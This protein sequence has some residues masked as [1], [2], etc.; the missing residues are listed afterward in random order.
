M[1]SNVVG[2]IYFWYSMIF[3]I[4]RTFSVAIAAAQIH[5]ESKKPLLVIRGLSTECWN[6]EVSFPDKV[7]LTILYI[8]FFFSRSF[9]SMSS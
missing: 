4:G 5:E 3:L 8:F 2:A 1:H 6:T 7:D 9:V